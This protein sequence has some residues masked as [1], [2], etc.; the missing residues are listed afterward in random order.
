M[1]IPSRFH[2][3]ETKKEYNLYTFNTFLDGKTT[4]NFQ[5]VAQEM[6]Q[7]VPLILEQVSLYIC[8]QVIH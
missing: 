3:A 4:K 8:Y 2:T 5:V 7:R 1:K 6:F